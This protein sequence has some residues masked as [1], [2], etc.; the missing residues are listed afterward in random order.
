[1]SFLHR[2]HR[3][4]RNPRPNSAPPLEVKVATLHD[5]LRPSIEHGYSMA[6][7][8]QSGLEGWRQF[9]LALAAQVALARYGCKLIGGGEVLPSIYAAKDE[10]DFAMPG[11]VT[12]MTCKSKRRF[13]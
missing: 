8:V 4:R 9:E 6:G 2:W 10:V 11:S 5:L 1:M 12:D 7:S 3:N 13:Y